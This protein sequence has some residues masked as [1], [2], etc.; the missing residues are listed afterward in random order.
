MRGL[1]LL[2]IVFSVPVFADTIYQC[3]DVKGKVTLQ[4]APC[5]S[6]TTDRV[7][8]S[9]QDASRERYLSAGGDPYQSYARG[10]MYGTT[11]RIS[12]DAYAAARSS[13]DA[14]ASSGDVRR[15]QEANSRVEQAGRRIAEQ[16]C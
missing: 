7:V 10:V 6:A 14:A 8:R 4:D 11:C 3:R 16:G 13:A 1:L 15:M 5:G 9:G 2:S 12:R